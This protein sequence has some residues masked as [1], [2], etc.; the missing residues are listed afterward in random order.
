MSLSR[1]QEETNYW[2]S[3][4]DMFLVFFVLAMAVA[5]GKVAQISAGEKY[6]IEDIVIETCY[7]VEYTNNHL[8]P[9]STIPAPPPCCDVDEY[10]TRQLSDSL[11]KVYACLRATYQPQSEQEETL[12]SMENDYRQSLDDKRYKDCVKLIS[13][14]LGLDEKPPT[15][16]QLRNINEK[17]SGE[18]NGSEVERQRKQLEVLLRQMESRQEELTQCQNEKQEL[19]TRVEQLENDIAKLRKLLIETEKIRPLMEEIDRLRQ[20]VKGQENIIARLTE[21]LT[22]LQNE[23][24]KLR[25]EKT[26]IDIEVE[27]RVAELIK[28]FKEANRISKSIL[29]EQDIAFDTGK[30][31]PHIKGRTNYDKLLKELKGYLNT[32]STNTYTIE[33]IGFTDKTS[34]EEINAVLGLQRAWKFIDTVYDD[35]VKSG[36]S[37]DLLDKE[38]IDSRRT[39]A[40]LKFR[41]YSA[42][43]TLAKTPDNVQHAPS[44][45]LEVLVSPDALRQ[46]NSTTFEAN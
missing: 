1:N 45:R 34:G 35:L 15:D 7:L 20:Q 44:R 38:Q 40:R 2:P 26:D 41:G 28:K 37:P 21:E 32:D 5:S 24:N 36:I 11:D 13:V 16:M 22:K 19:K 6:L 12:S 14:L 46:E 42:G 18:G 4:S 9:E 31:I 23:I 43:K 30:S 3:I 33:V 27:R 39:G 25:I 17:L 29:E 8:E 10:S